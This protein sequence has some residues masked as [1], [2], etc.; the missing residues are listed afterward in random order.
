ML[1]SETKPN[2]AILF[3]DRQ[4][5]DLIALRKGFTEKKNAFA[6]NAI[7]HDDDHN[8]NNANNIFGWKE[9]EKLLG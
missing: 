9:D 5:R 3:G 8:N 4:P 2:T 7:S 6:Y 1:C